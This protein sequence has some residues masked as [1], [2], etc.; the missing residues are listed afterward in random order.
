[1]YSE[2]QLLEEQIKWVEVVIRSEIS[3]VGGEFNKTKIFHYMS[4]TLASYSTLFILKIPV[5]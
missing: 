4:L 3:L 1:M 2:K 5:H